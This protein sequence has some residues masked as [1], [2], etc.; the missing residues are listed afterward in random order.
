MGRVLPVFASRPPATIRGGFGLRQLE[1]FAE[2]ELAAE[3]YVDDV[4]DGDE[5][6]RYVDT[7]RSVSAFEERRGPMPAMKKVVIVPK[8]PSDPK[9]A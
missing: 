7:I 6:E 5:F 1:L 8:D 3:L 2:S 9:V 4:L